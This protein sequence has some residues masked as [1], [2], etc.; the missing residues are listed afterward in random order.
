MRIRVLVVALA[1]L[2]PTMSSIEATGTIP[3]RWAVCGEWRQVTTPET[4]AFPR[5][6]AVVSPYEAWFAGYVGEVRGLPTVR[7]WTGLRWEPEAFPT[8]VGALDEEVAGFTV[9]SSNDVWAVGD[10]R[11]SRRYRPLVARWNGERWHL[12][13]LR[14]EDLFGGLNATAVTPSHVMWAVGSTWGTTS[15][16]MAGGATLVVRFNGARWHRVPSPSPGR[17][18]Q[19]SDL[20]FVGGDLWAVGSYED[21]RGVT[22]TLAARRHDGRWRTFLGRRGSLQAVD[23]RST[24]LVW[25]VGPGKDVGPQR[26]FVQR[27]DGTAWK[28]VRLLARGSALQDV[29]VASP[30]DAW[31]VGYRG[32]MYERPRP[33]ILRRHGSPWRW[34]QAPDVPGRFFA[35]DGTSNNLWALSW[36]FRS[37]PG[38]GPPPLDTFHR[39]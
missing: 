4:S 17:A 39:C 29:V 9:V 2:V 1:F 10:W 15:Y 11:G 22:R 31:A 14:L 35:L 33:L 37:P 13:S 23:A 30:T 12:V 7:H 6:I 18:S 20:V 25:A 8:H 21:P 5:D 24:D 34:A 26:A 32:G 3:A 36:H 28:T 27:W 19:F 16:G 38:D